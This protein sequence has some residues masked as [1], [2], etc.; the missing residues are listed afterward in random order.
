MDLAEA[1]RRHLT[2]WFSDRHPATRVR[3]AGAYPA[4]ENSHAFHAPVHEGLPGHLAEAVRADARRGGP[5]AS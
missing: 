5:T 3:I 2:T 1:H 4:D